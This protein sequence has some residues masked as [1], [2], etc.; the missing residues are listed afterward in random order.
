MRYYLRKLAFYAFAGWI[1][2]TL[3]FL[4]PRMVKGDPVQVVLAKAQ[5]LAPLP[6]SA[7]HALELQFGQTHDSLL[8]QYWHYLG[9]IF[10]GNF[11]LSVTYYPSPVSHIVASA[12]PW[13]VVLVGLSTIISYVVGQ[14]LGSYVGW[15]RGAGLTGSS[16]S[17]RSCPPSRTSGSRSSSSTSSGS[18]C[19]GSP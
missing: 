7:R 2:I 13:T 11:G 17:R 10:T 9:S 12:L 6:A 4:L 5:R 15:R 8:V 1:A 14:L 16:R 3:N 18:R 19:S